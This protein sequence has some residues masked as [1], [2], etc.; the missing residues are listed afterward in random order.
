MRFETTGRERIRS[1][2][3]CVLYDNASGEIK[4]VHHVVTIEGADETPEDTIEKRAL[5]LA[6]GVG[7]ET[8]GLRSLHVDAEK[9]D[10]EKTFKVDVETRRLVAV[11]EEPEN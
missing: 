9:I 5:E 11:S 3:S 2:K 6:Q 1:T 7:V 4:H 8:K 10:P